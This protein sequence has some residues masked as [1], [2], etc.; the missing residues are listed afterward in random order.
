LGPGRPCHRRGGHGRRSGSGPA[1]RGLRRPGERPPVTESWVK[2]LMPYI[3]AHRRDVLLSFGGALVGLSVT[4]LTPV[5]QKVIIDDVILGRR[6][7]L[8]PWLALLIGAGL[9]RFVAA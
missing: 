6:R 9:V 3:R 4:A 7:P 5:I 1:G 8:A 2:R